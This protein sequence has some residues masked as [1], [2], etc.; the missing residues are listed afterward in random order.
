[1]G[2]LC[3][4]NY[5]MHIIYQHDEASNEY[6]RRIALNLFVFLIKYQP[7]QITQEQTG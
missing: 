4:S 7:Y 6:I 1:M 5:H 2:T 3:F